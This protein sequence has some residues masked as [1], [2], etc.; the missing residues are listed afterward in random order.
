MPQPESLSRWYVRPA[1]AV[2]HHIDWIHVTACD[3]VSG[4][5]LVVSETAYPGWE[6]RVNGEN[7]PLESVGGRIGVTLPESGEPAEIIFRYEPTWLYLG[8][9]ISGAAFAAFAVFVLIRRSTSQT[10]PTIV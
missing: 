10:E 4:A 2:Q 8:A 6:V 9:A 3:Y 5:V 7:A 1:C